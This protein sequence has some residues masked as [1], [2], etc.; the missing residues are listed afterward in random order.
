MNKSSCKI[1]PSTSSGFALKLFSEIAKQDKENVLV[2]P[3]SAYAALSMTV[4]GASGQ[5][6]NQMLDVLGV[7][8]NMI[9]DLNKRN[10]AVFTALNSNKNVQMEIANAIYVDRTTP[11]KKQFIELCQ[12]IYSADAHSEDFND[13]STVKAINAWCDAKTH[14]K[15][16]RILDKL[17]TQEKMVYLM[18]SFS[19]E[20]GSISLH[21]RALWTTSLRPAPAKKLR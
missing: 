19:R 2:C 18:P 14:G 5:T 10:Q 6:R 11:F 8:S 16:S 13:P 7:G 17:S 12:N 4:N 9:E 1:T 20:H 15:I 21:S 3:F